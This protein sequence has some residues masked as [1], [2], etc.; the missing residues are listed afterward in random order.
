[1]N[2]PIT[3]QTEE[4]FNAGSNFTEG[5]KQFYTTR[6]CKQCGKADVYCKCPKV[7]WFDALDDADG[8][9]VANTDPATTSPIRPGGKGKPKK[10]SEIKIP[11]MNPEVK[12]DKHNWKGLPYLLCPKCNEHI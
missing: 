12:C 5:R 1:M 6:T 7:H 2:Y 9:S 4:L 3:R 11:S 8:S 10:K